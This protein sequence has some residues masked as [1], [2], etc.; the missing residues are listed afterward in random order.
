[1]NNLHATSTPSR[2]L[3]LA[4]YQGALE[5]VQGR[6]C[7][8][9]H[10]KRQPLQG[11]VWAVAIGK[12][13]ASM[14]AG[15]QDVIQIEQALLV[16]K[17]G[18]APGR[19]ASIEV[20]ESGHPVPDDRSLAAGQRLLALM[21]TAP[22]DVEW[23][24][25]IS[26]GASSLIDVLQKDLT[27]ADLQRVNQWLL[28]SGLSIDAMNAVR[29]RL[30]R[31]KG[32]QL[33]RYLGGRAARALLI[34]DVPGDDPSII[35]SGLLTAGAVSK[36][37]AENLP[38]WLH[39]LLVGLPDV[40]KQTECAGVETQIVAR[41]DD[42]LNAVIA[43]AREQGLTVFRHPE[44]LI[45]EA[46]VVGRNIALRLQAAEP[47]VYLWGG[48]T[49]VTLPEHPG[50]GGRCQQLALAAAIKLAGDE[51]IT[52]LAAGTDGSDGPGEIAGACIDGGTLA[53]GQN[54]G[55]NARHALQRADAGTFLEASGDLLET[56]PTG[57]N[58]TDLVIALKRV[59]ADSFSL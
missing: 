44:R 51:R 10:L 31:I 20:I 36:G 58:V 21:A 46:A 28:A 48:E 12:A 14:L 3:L 39:R 35:G 2:D 37:T 49:T 11:R 30:S 38:E 42:A 57:T 16:T 25:L 53:R 55:L 22:V 43:L 33:C 40:A 45:G 19:V 24:F 18:Y 59:S 23:L 5:A 27:L 52:L 34:S 32:G 54:E 15:A 29:R 6:R 17:P 47:G 56:G 4:F 9:E 50:Q 8:A 1:M 41:L 13:A 26:G 7:V